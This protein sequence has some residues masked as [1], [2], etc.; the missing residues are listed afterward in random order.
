MTTILESIDKRIASFRRAGIGRW[1]WKRRGNA[2]GVCSGWIIIGGGL[3]SL[4]KRDDR[5]AIRSSARSSLVSG[6]SPTNRCSRV[7]RCR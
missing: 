6:A 4:A 3:V 1:R 5:E 7:G 2:S